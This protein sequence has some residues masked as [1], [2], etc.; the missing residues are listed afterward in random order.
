MIV[1]E[2][3]FAHRP[4][5]PILW[6]K[7]ASSR[8]L[9]IAKTCYGL[10]PVDSSYSIGAVGELAPGRGPNPDVHWP[11]PEFVPQCR[12]QSADKYLR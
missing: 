12:P 8:R 1:L 9:F 10:T 4:A 2:M 5:L 7:T 3:Y 6:A 11:P